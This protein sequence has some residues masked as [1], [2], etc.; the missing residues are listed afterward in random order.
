MT[1]QQHF[2]LSLSKP[3]PAALMTPEYI[4]HLTSMIYLWGWPMVNVHNRV[5]QFRDVPAAFYMNGIAPVAPVNHLCMLTDYIR[6]QQRAVA[7]PNQDVVYGIGALD[8]SI[9]PVII[10]VPDF[11]DRFWIYQLC[12]ERTDSFGSMGKP[13]GTEPGFYLLAGE[14]WNGAW[15]QGVSGVFICPTQLGIVMPRV[16]QWDEQEDRA[17]IQPLLKQIM[18]YPLSRFDGQMKS[19]DWSKTPTVNR[20]MSAGKQETAWVRPEVFFDQLPQLLKE[21]PPMPGEEAI[22]THVEAFLAA[23]QTRPE[24]K[25][26]AVS[27]AAA[28]EVEL[29]TPLFDFMNVGYPAKNNWTTQNN[30]A[31][32][33]VDYL[34]RAACAKSNIFVNQPEETRYFY[35]DLDADGVRLNGKD[36]YTLTFAKDQIPPVKGFWSLTVY[37]KEHFF[38]PNAID[39]YSVGTKNKSLQLNEDGSLTIYIQHEA[40]EERHMQNWLPAPQ[41]EFSLYL[42][43]YWPEGSVLNDQWAPAAAVRQSRH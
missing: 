6:P 43:C 27:Y 30:G 18:M 17:A 40:P 11:G 28:A 31:R 13:H 36:A 19:T 8:V 25:K 41:K 2:D 21:V 24:L 39:R 5:A 26:L 9:E 34:T 20:T 4:K 37:N 22:Y 38:E 42:R 29:I 23:L 12:D 1:T 33:G 14:E 35:L 3:V 15:P 16:F 10:Q 7:C 32:F